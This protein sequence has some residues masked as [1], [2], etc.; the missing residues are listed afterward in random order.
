VKIVFAGTPG[1]AATALEAIIGA[2]HAVVGVLTQPDRPVGRGRHVRASPVKALAEK[3]GLPVLQPASL[4]SGGVVDAI[5]AS[6]MDAMVVAAYGLLVPRALLELPPRGGINIHASLLPRWRGAAPIQRAL[7]AG[8]ETTGITIMQMDEGLDTGP[9]LLQEALPIAPEET[10]GTLRDRLAALGARLIVEA[11]AAPQAPRLQDPAYVTYA[12]KIDRSEARIH[13]R[14]SAAAIDRQ[15]RAFN[16]APGAYTSRNGA[17]LK[18][19]RVRVEQGAAGDPGVVTTADAAGIVV[20]CGAGALR[21]LELQR[22]GGKPLPARAFL[23]GCDI[24]PGARLG[25]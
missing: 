6:R 2:G 25:E 21:I 15:V 3:H 12:P 5:R 18:I 23:A 11:L 20:A 7:L 13:W 1:F 14:H 24:V 17:L 4:A 22:A 19:W 16:P 8:D 9:I 10:A